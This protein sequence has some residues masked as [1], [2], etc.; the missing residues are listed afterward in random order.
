LGYLTILFQEQTY[1]IEWRGKIITCGKLRA[2]E[3]VVDIEEK[4]RDLFT[5]SGNL[6]FEAGV[7]RTE[8][9]SII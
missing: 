9:W 4:E 5:I 7:S 6:R 3:F 1:V 2:G 8:A